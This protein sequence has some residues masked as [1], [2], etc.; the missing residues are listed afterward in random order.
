MKSF[1]VLYETRTLG[2]R[3]VLD[4]LKRIR[5]HE[6][7]YIIIIHT[8]VCIHIFNCL[9][10]VFISYHLM[11]SFILK[12]VRCFWTYRILC[13]NYHRINVL[14]ITRYRCS[15]E[16]YY[17]VRAL[18]TILYTKHILKTVYW[19]LQQKKITKKQKYENIVV[20]SFIWKTTLNEVYVWCC[21]AYKCKNKIIFFQCIIFS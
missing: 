8:S 1:F 7:K 21:F 15:Y 4:T 17:W 12:I 3:V 2:P 13:K 6:I 20:G 19:V 5:T 11:F 14:I 16:Y 18:L 9:V 10:K